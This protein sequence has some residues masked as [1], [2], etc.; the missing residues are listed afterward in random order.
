VYTPKLK[1][2]KVIL[3]SFSEFYSLDLTISVSF[4]MST[5]RDN[6]YVDINIT[7]TIPS[8]KD[9]VTLVKLLFIMIRSKVLYV[10]ILRSILLRVTCPMYEHVYV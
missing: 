6:N 10:V 7:L 2:N 1:Q 5:G 8:P 9:Q 4:N 3:F